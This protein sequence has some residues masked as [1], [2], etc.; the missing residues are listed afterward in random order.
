[1]TE[2]VIADLPPSTELVNTSTLNSSFLYSAFAMLL[3]DG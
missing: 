2:F 3:T 1:M